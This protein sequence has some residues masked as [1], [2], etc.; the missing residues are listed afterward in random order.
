[1]RNLDER[2]TS[3][4]RYLVDRSM[5]WAFVIVLSA[6]C[7]LGWQYQ[8]GTS[9]LWAA[10]A[11]AV[12]LGEVGAI[13]KAVE[14]FR[15]KN[16]IAVGA[17]AVVWAL[18]FSYSFV[19]SMGVAATTQDTGAA[20]RQAKATTYEH[21]SSD[22]QALKTKLDLL[23][24]ARSKMQPTR[25]A[26]DARAVMA[27]KE[28]HKWFGLTEKCTA[29]KGPQ[30]RAWCDDYRAAEADLQLWDAIARQD[31]RI[32]QARADLVKAQK[33]RR[34]APVVASGIDPFAKLVNNYTGADIQSVA[35]ATAVQK[36]VTV[37]TI[38]TLTALMLFGAAAGAR[39]QSVDATLPPPLPAALPPQNDV[40]YH[41]THT[42]QLDPRFDGA[43]QALKEL[44]DFYRGQVRAA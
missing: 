26:A 39:R 38:L 18:C 42:T 9:W 30:T 23:Q 13:H 10:I 36:T 40:R 3:A 14:A 5:L 7:I 25:S 27:T 41:H 28:A 43:R 2:L 17:G 31:D 32:D 34:D 33:V 44:E 4:V 1:M 12:V 29:T 20:L 19:Q 11:V 37:N 22:E 15:E 35:D 21:A 6:A 8:S 16:W 24:Q